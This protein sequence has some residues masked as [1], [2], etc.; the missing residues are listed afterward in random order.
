[1]ISRSAVT[2]IPFCWIPSAISM[3]VLFGRATVVTV[4]GLTEKFWENARPGI[5]TVPLAAS[6]PVMKRD[7]CAPP[8]KLPGNMSQNSFPRL[9]GAARATGASIMPT[10]SATIVPISPTSDRRPIRTELPCAAL[11]IP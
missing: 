4:P 3:S 9:S 1:M 6:G 8:P 5:S 7:F 11:I 10:V 2:W